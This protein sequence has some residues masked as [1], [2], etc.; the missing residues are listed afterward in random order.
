MKSIDLDSIPTYTKLELATHQLD[1]SIRLLLDED[2]CISAITLAGAAEEILGNILKQKGATSAHQ[3]LIDECL[4][5]MRTIPGEE[6]KPSDFHEIFAYHRNELKHLRQG[7]D[8][9][10]NAECAYPV[11]DRAIENIRRLGVKLSPLALRY[12]DFRHSL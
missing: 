10:I 2:D 9:T 1:R 12:I 8:I 6:S 7:S 4:D 3:E 5:L 11:V